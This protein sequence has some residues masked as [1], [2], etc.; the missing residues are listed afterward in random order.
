MGRW[1]GK[2]IKSLE[3]DAIAGKAGVV[4]FVSKREHFLLSRMGQ[5]INAKRGSK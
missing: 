2:S 3:S 1:P 4:C 5:N